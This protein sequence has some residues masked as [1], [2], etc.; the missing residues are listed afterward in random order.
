MIVDLLKK[1]VEANNADA[2]RK[3]NLVALPADGSAILTGDIHGHRRNFE[4][5]VTFADLD[6]NPKRHV[7][8]QEIIHG[9]PEDAEGGCLSYKLLFDV[10]RYK[11]AFPDRIHIIMGNHDTAFINSSEVMKS[12]KE[13]NRA[14]SSAVE[15][16]F[17]RAGAEIILKIKQFL[18][19]QPLAVRC[20][21]RIW[22][23]H[24]LP[25][26]HAAEKFDPGVIDRPLKVND[27]VRPGSAYLLTWGRR[28]SQS[29]LDKM[30]EA[31]DV[32]SFVLGHQRQ[33][34]GWSRAGGN[35]IIIASDHNHGCLLPVNLDESY[36]IERL[37]GSIV[38]LTSIA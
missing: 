26:D 32:D 15:R 8:L 19:S 2:F 13:M 29:L 21:N 24:S 4:R 11:L 12:G 5:I 1:G 6:Q 14:M 36:T 17:G 31:F 18:F 16:E 20:Q 34:Q 35:L 22:V 9:G 27:V 30:A 10:I 37:A 3:G 38:P 33:E 25:S 7:V 23:S 28:H